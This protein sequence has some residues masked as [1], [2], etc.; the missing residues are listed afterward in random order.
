V[1]DGNGTPLQR[2]H[3]PF[4]IKEIKIKQGLAI[5]PIYIAIL[6]TLAAGPAKKETWCARIKIPPGMLSLFQLIVQSSRGGLLSEAASQKRRA[7]TNTKNLPP[8][9]DVK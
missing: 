8:R 7:A 2:S 1:L 5:D 4:A 6:I 3:G 9:L